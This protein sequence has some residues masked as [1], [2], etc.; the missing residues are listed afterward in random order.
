LLNNSSYRN[1]CKMSVVLFALAVIFIIT[2]FSTSVFRVPK[3]SCFCCGK[4]TIILS[5]NWYDSNVSHIL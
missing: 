5:K 1:V 2:L 3:F 4:F